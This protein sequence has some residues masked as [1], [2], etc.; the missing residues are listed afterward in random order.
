MRTHRQGHGRREA[1]TLLE[2]ILATGLTALLAV[3]VSAAWAGFGRPAANVVARCRVAQEAA[4][5]VAALSNDLGGYLADAP[6]RLGD[7]TQLTVVGRLQPGGTQ[8]WL[9][10][11][12]GSSPNG[13]ADW[14]SPD[15]VVV[16][17]L[18]ES[19][20]IRTNQATSTSFTVAN[21][22]QAFTVQDL[23][24]G[25]FEIQLTFS[26]RGVTQT[27]TLMGRDP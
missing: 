19:S 1:F 4:M 17:A 3:L 22:V 26:Y 16:Y 23:G 27:F 24:G 11:D 18:Q 9:C 5:A 14:G 13:V 25:L 7:T 20:L 10:F 6:G 15:T 2:T 21:D 12:G 8:L